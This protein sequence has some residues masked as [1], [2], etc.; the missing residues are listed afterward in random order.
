MR[1]TPICTSTERCCSRRRMARPGKGTRKPS[2]TC[3]RRGSSASSTCSSRSSMAALASVRASCRILTTSRTGQ[4]VV[5]INWPVRT[6]AARA[7]SMWTM[8]IEAC[9]ASSGSRPRDKVCSAAKASA[10]PRW[11]SASTASNCSPRWPRWSMRSAMCSQPSCSASQFREA[12]ASPRRLD[13]KCSHNRRKS[14]SSCLSRVGKARGRTSASTAVRMGRQ[15][16]MTAA[17]RR[18]RARRLMRMAIICSTRAAI[19]PT[20]A[21][22]IQN[23][24]RRKGSLVTM[25]FIGQ[26][27]GH[28][29]GATHAGFR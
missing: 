8:P 16:A 19:R 26:P 7:G 6:A 14:V 12:R 9:T 13:W 4:L 24:A 1:S 20:A 23:A 21:M 29:V 15:R 2:I 18:S 28:D 27:V 3:S 17:L 5:P 10:W 22:P 11:P 25:S